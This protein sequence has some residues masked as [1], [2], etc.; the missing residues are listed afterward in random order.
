MSRTKTVLL[1]CVLAILLSACEDGNTNEAASSRNNTLRDLHIERF[2]FSPLTALARFRTDVPSRVTVTIVGQDGEDLTKSFDDYGTDH[3]IPLLG[4]YPDFRNTVIVR[5]RSRDGRSAVDSLEITTSPLPR[6]YQRIPI[7]VVRTQNGSLAEGFIL[8]LLSREYAGSREE[9]MFLVVDH[10]GKIRWIYTG[11]QWFMGKMAPDGNLVIQMSNSYERTRRTY[12]RIVQ[13]ALLWAGQPSA[14]KELRWNVKGRYDPKATPGEGENW[15]QKLLMEIGDWLP[16]SMK[17]FDTLT[18]I[19]FFGRERDSWTASGYS[20]HH[21]FIFLPNG[22]LLALASSRTSDADLIVEIGAKSRAVDR[23]IDFK[24]I[25]D[26]GRPPA[27]RHV[28]NSDWAHLN[29]L[30]F[31]TEDSTLVVSARNQ[32]AIVKL[33][34]DSLRI[35]WILGTH[36]KWSWM[37][38]DYLL[39]PVGASFDWPWGQHA[40]TPSPSHPNRILVYDN[41]NRRSYTA[42]LPPWASYSR[43]VEYEIDDGAMTVR[44]TWEYG[45]ER[46]SNLFTPVVGSAEYLPNGNRLICF[47]AIA[48]DLDGDPVRW[49]EPTPDSTRFKNKNVKS[50]VHVIETTG[51][52]P[53]SLLF[54]LSIQDA[55]ARTYMGY[56]AYRAYRILLY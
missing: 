42:P 14:M 17:E 41:G 6:A 13:A 27:V 24:K 4:L 29:A 52:A 1:V 12:N 56:L 23:V 9:G 25:L 50:S 51:D 3:E 44:Q 15:F 49:I 11:D 19:D 21:D 45:R 48:K 30:F 43:A 5:L 36:E 55:D 33:T 47:G 7:H 46:G 16:L 32:S 34:L 28:L 54:E 37:Y 31:D 20:L 8:L 40:P 39:R 38:R 53:A 22:N 26:A 10:F 2:R 18:E 35:R